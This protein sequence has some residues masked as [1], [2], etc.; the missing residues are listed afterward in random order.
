MFN[1]ILQSTLDIK[2]PAPKIRDG[3]FIT[4]VP[5][6][7]LCKPLSSGT[8]KSDTLAFDN[9]GV[10]ARPTQR[11]FGLLLPGVFR[12][13]H[14][15]GRTN[16]RLSEELLPRT[17]PAHRIWMI[18]LIVIITDG[19]NGCQRGTILLHI[20]HS[21]FPNKAM[22]SNRNKY[23]PSLLNSCELHYTMP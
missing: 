1:F 18:E 15:P 12:L 11:I 6:C 5:P 2:N 20:G 4:V 22:N 13:V 17:S 14:S 7:L 8:G 9:G 16:P 19:G 3:I 21:L 10:P 23:S